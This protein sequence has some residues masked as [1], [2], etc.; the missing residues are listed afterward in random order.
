MQDDHPFKSAAIKEA[1]KRY[2]ES[3]KKENE[4]SGSYLKQLQTRIEKDQRD[5]D[6][7]REDK[8]KKQRVFRESI[9]KQI[10][11]REG[12]AEPLSLAGE[13]TGLTPE[14]PEGERN[15]L[16]SKQKIQ[17][18]H[19]KTLLQK[20]ISQKEENAKEEK[21]KQMQ[22]ELEMIKDNKRQMDLQLQ[23][24]KQEKEKAKKSM[25]AN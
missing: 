5:F 9:Q 23:K 25:E 19:L 12:R 8:A 13:M 1:L 2:E 14:Q 4:E 21:S 20:Q 7:E 16:R 15:I 6:K 22:E 24:A 10:K 17:Q 18:E 3:L 11:D